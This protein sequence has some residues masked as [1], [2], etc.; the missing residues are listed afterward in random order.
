[1]IAAYRDGLVDE[2]MLQIDF[3][4]PENRGLLHECATSSSDR[5]RLLAANYYL[6]NHYDEGFPLVMSLTKS[7]DTSVQ[8]VAFSYLDLTEDRRA[9]EAFKALLDPKDEGIFGHA[10]IAL[11]QWPECVK[12]LEP[13]THS[14]SRHIRLSAKTA[15]HCFQD[16]WFH[17]SSGGVLPP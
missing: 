14:K 12:L 8:A 9:L 13:F 11:I 6:E 4:A 10:A 5:L 16:P 7:K 15:I 17:H 3:D 1:M 2:F